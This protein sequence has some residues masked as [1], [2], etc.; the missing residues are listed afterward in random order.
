MHKQFMDLRKGERFQFVHP[1]RSDFEMIFV[2]SGPTTYRSEAT[3][4]QYRMGNT[5]RQVDVMEQA[6]KEIA[7]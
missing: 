5:G 3:G 4:K 7:Q 6:T 2:K 1:W